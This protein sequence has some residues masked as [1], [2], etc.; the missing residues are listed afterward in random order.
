MPRS[1]HFPTT[2][3]L[4]KLNCTG[5]A[6]PA[7]TFFSVV[8]A[9]ALDILSRVWPILGISTHDRYSPR[10]SPDQPKFKLSK[11]KDNSAIGTKEQCRRVNLV[12]QKG[13]NGNGNGLDFGNQHRNREFTAIGSLQTQND[14]ADKDTITGYHFLTSP[15]CRLSY[16]GHTLRRAVAINL[17]SPCRSI[18]CES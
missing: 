18:H 1:S 4:P 11:P 8:S 14:T 2:I 15:P 5:R 10:R 13:L 6:E 17:Y 3:L 7:H 16:I 9:C 12:T